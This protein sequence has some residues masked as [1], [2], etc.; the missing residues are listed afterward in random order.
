MR[1]LA[2]KVARTLQPSSANENKWAEQSSWCAWARLSAE[3]NMWLICH[4]KNTQK[5]SNFCL[6][7]RLLTL[8]KWPTCKDQTST[9]VQ[10]HLYQTGSAGALHMGCALQCNWHTEVRITCETVRGHVIKD[11]KKMQGHLKK[12]MPEG[13]LLL[14]LYSQFQAVMSV[15]LILIIFRYLDQSARHPTEMLIY[16]EVARQCEGCAST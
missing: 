2:S 15:R 11:W 1:R 12:K 13:S 16:L 10:W 6:T 3:E 14:L 7:A 8:G 4:W 5:I 9:V